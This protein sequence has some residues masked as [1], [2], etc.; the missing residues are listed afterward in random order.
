MTHGREG[1]RWIAALVENDT[2][3]EKGRWTVR[4]VSIWTTGILIAVISVHRRRRVTRI[5]PKSR[6]RWMTSYRF[7]TAAT[8]TPTTQG[9][10]YGGT[11]VKIQSSFLQNM[12]T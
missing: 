1:G 11:N 8:A 6:P 5:M 2:G 9:A 4:L 3:R 12:I 7:S 10:H